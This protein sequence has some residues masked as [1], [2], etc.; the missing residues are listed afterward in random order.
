MRSSFR[1]LL[2]GLCLGWLVIGCSY[3][4]PEVDRDSVL[5]ETDIREVM[6]IGGGWLS[7]TKD[8]V[9]D[10]QT[11]SASAGNLV[12]RSIYNEPDADYGFTISD[13]NGLNIYENESVGRSYLSYVSEDRVYP[14][15]FFEQEAAQLSYGIDLQRTRNFAHSG[16]KSFHLES[17]DKQPSILGLDQLSLGARINNI[18]PDLVIIQFGIEEVLPYAM[19]GGQGNPNVQTLTDLSTND[20]ISATLYEDQL[21]NII[22]RVKAANSMSKVLI[23][24]T[25]N[26][27]KFANFYELVNFTVAPYIS[28]EEIAENYDY[29]NNFPFGFNYVLG[30]YMNNHG[31]YAD[32]RHYVWSPEFDVPDTA[33]WSWRYVVTDTDLPLIENYE[34]ARGGNRIMSFPQFREIGR[35]ERALFEVDK[36]VYEERIGFPLTPLPKSL[37]L[38]HS[39]YRAIEA[40]IGEFNSSVIRVASDYEGVEVMNLYGMF[41]DLFNGEYRGHRIATPSRGVLVDNVPLLPSFLTNGFFSTD[42]INPNARGSAYLANLIIE[43]LNENFGYSIKG[44]PTN[45]YGGNKILKGF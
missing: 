37:F 20:I 10:S 45:K 30:E 1:I 12:L 21:R 23:L 43:S 25:P 24:N 8:G 26:V 28:R 33:E 3:E 32:K 39:E 9:F 17:D 34:Y 4:F 16:F 14:E 41:E 40:R 44:V 42:G 2:F 29:V 35:D 6:I 15:R 31:S 13:G 11:K 19:A 38:S 5:S 7:G 36:L 27:S 22:D 18:K